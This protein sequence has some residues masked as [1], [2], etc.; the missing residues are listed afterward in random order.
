MRR[1]FHVLELAAFDRPE[2]DIS[3]DRHED[4]A[5]RDEEVEDVHKSRESDFGGPVHFGRPPWVVRHTSHRKHRAAIKHAYGLVVSHVEIRG[6]KRASADLRALYA[7]SR[8]GVSPLLA[9]WATVK[10]RWDLG[11]RPGESLTQSVEE[12]LLCRRLK[13]SVGNFYFVSLASVGFVESG[14]INTR[15]ILYINGIVR[16]INVLAWV[17]LMVMQQAKLG[18]ENCADLTD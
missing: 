1:T 2:K 12:A 9:E 7:I 11:V 18:S 17:V 14:G 16:D 3:D 4:Q 6:H 13:R 8:P 15:N 5:E 10:S